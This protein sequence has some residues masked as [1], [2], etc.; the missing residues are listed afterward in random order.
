MG[1]LKLTLIVAI[2]IVLCGC[3]NNPLIGDGE[4]PIDKKLVNQ[5]V[6]GREHGVWE[7]KNSEGKLTEVGRYEQ[8]LKSGDWT[9]FDKDGEKRIIWEPLTADTLGIE[10]NLPENFVLEEQ[11][12]NGGYLRFAKRE[13]SG[14]QFIF[15][16]SPIEIA[17]AG[18]SIGEY[19][20]SLMKEMNTIFTLNDYSKTQLIST[21][22]DTVLF[23]QLDVSLNGNKMGI[24]T[25]IAKS[26][27]RIV[28]L[29]LMFINAD[30][31]T[32]YKFFYG[33]ILS[34]YLE[35]NRIIDAEAEL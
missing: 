10:L 4:S 1:R 17:D 23:L 24:Y 29:S 15:T 14:E 3:Q 35:G 30:H 8:G 20:A 21:E 12:L 33:I 28:D 6:E 22:Q 26:G 2:F 5:L 27:S 13:E 32:A 11:I 25:A 31:L 9:Y 34:S 18:G 16:F 7:Y 19:R